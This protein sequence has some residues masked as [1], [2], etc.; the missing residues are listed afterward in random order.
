MKRARMSNTFS[1]MAYSIEVRVPYLDHTVVEA[2]RRMAALDKMDPRENKP[3][4]VHALGDKMVQQASRKPKRGFTVPMQSWMRQYAD[5]LAPIA[6]RA[7]SV[8]RDAVRVLWRQFREGRL[9]WSRAW[10]L[11]VLGAIG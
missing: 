4:L 11:T 6:M 5:E 2:V 9:H 8:D 10:A 1:R 7:T 3:V